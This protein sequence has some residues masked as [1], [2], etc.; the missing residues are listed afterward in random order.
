MQ[1]NRT[2]AQIGLDC[3]RRFS[4]ATARDEQG[5]LV[6]RERIEHE[7]RDAVREQLRRWPRGVPVVLEA[8]FGWGWLSDE[9]QA[10][11]LDPHLASSKKV[12][13]WRE[14]RGMAKSNRI[15]ADLLAEL[16]SQQPRWWEVWLAPPAVRDQR[17]WMRYRAGLVGQQTQ[18]KNRLHAV[19][20]R[21][22]V[23]QPFSDLFGKEGRAW[24]EGLATGPDERLR[25]TARLVLSGLLRQLASLRGEIARAVR[26]LRRQIAKSP[27]A[28]R[29]RTLPGI[30]WILAYTIVA[31]VGR[32]ERFRS[33]KHL[34]SYSLLVPRSYDSG[35]DDDG[36]PKGRHVGHAGRRTLQ[37]A[38]IEAAHGAVRS[39]GRFRAIFDRVTDGG[40]RNRNRGYIA[41]A[42]ELCRIAYVLWKKDVDY[43]ER[44]P[45]RPGQRPRGAKPIRPRK[46]LEGK[47]LEG[48]SL[49]GKS[50]E[51][52]KQSPLRSVTRPGTGQPDRPMVAGAGR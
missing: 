2:V 29:L 42:H 46:S 10:A 15:D 23:V 20:H 17:E 8:T 52:K 51:G 40:K 50:L 24:L 39:G 28:R 33:A 31:E 38:W 48:K 27:A 34:A 25:E 22:G 6:W 41:V 49:E 37:W 14:A 44:P 5:Q 13:A 45:Q 16:W 11:G 9:I 7:D 30:A 36:D 26:V 18:V 35:D 12:A 1:R 21:H 19:L 4:D 47:S 32:I 3:H 43:S